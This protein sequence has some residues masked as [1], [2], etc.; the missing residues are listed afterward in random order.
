MAAKQAMASTGVAGRTRLPETGAKRDLAEMNAFGII[1]KMGDS[2]P[3]WI[4]TKKYRSWW[5]SH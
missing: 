5:G 3:L 4:L 1:E 2:P